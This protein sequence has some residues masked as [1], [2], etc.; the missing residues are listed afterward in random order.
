M[1][2]SFDS[3]EMPSTHLDMSLDT[4]EMGSME[5]P[6]LPPVVDLDLSADLYECP[7]EPRNPAAMLG[8]S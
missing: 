3:L 7:A 2:A 5:L 1:E 4:M 8:H 6:G